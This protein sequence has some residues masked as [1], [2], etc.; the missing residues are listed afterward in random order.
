MTAAPSNRTQPSLVEQ[1]AIPVPMGGKRRLR[2]MIATQAFWV[3]IVLVT[4]CAAMSYREPD[5]FG[6]S[7]NFFNITRNFAFIGVIALGMTPVIITG[8]LRLSGGSVTGLVPL[9]SGLPRPPQPPPFLP[10]WRD[11]TT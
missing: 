5:S 9:V 4:I 3:T 8:G 11:E 1:A 2:G 7:E 6:T 10:A